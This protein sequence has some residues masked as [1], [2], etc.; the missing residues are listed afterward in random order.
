MRGQTELFRKLGRK[1][2]GE[3]LNAVVREPATL[4]WLDAQANRK[5]QANVRWEASMKQLIK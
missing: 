4:V 1:H 3:L 5:G 2:F